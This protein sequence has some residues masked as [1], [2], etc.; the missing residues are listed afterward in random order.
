MSVLIQVG[1]SYDS[2]LEKVEKVTIEVAREVMEKIQGG[3]SE[4]EPFI[5][6]HTFGDSSINFSV[7]LRT[8]EFVNQYI[9]KH[10]FIKNCI[11]ATKKRVSK[12]RFPSVSAKPSRPYWPMQEK[13]I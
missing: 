3:V 6:Y 2:D 10:E 5:R 8:R 13:P 7:I 9:I 4:F 12:F 11:N 1:V